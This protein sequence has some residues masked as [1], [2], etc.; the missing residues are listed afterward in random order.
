MKLS[1][2]LDDH[3]WDKTREALC[4]D[5]QA[6]DDRFSRA[7]QLI[8][9]Q[10]DTQ[11]EQ[12]ADVMR[13][14]TVKPAYMLGPVSPATPA[15]GTNATA[16]QL[17]DPDR[18]ARLVLTSAARVGKQLWM[19]A[20]GGPW[21]HGPSDGAAL[22]SLLVFLAG[23]GAEEEWRREW[24]QVMLA[25]RLADVGPV[26]TPIVGYSLGAY[27]NVHRLH[28]SLLRVLDRRGAFELGEPDEELPDWLDAVCRAGGSQ[29]AALRDRPTFG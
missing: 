5:A 9:T 23:S 15:P 8:V 29:V 13:L 14:P 7:A 20:D 26:L 18:V 6:S 1:E 24:E 12:L 3:P 21:R 10:R 17:D 27:T 28:D 4:R 19:L 25:A 2:L 16:F 11:V 22:G